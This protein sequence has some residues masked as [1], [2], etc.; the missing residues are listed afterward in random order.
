MTL[1]SSAASPSPNNGFGEGGRSLQQRPPVTG[2]GTND[3][4][5]EQM[6]NHTE[7]VTRSPVRCNAPG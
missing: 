6:T 1:N 7:G 3:V 5:L 4:G 2:F